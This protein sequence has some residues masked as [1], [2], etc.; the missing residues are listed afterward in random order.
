MDF[1]Q[2]IE[3]L[4][5]ALDRWNPC[6]FNRYWIYWHERKV[7]KFIS[8]NIRT[9]KGRVDWDRVISNL[10]PTLQP[11]W[12]DDRIVNL[13]PYSDPQVVERLIKKYGGRHYISFI[14]V[15]GEEE[16]NDVRNHISVTLVSLAQR[17]NVAAEE[18][19]MNFLALITGE[20]IYR[21]SRLW[22]WQQYPELL[23]EKCKYCIY[24]YRY[25]GTFI[26][27]LYT[28]LKYSALYFPK[29]QCLGEGKFGRV[30]QRNR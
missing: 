17:G 30:G 16:D 12:H 11:R 21:D 26:G 5:R 10:D 23:S 1:D 13:L 22:Q 6:R 24:H 25:T 2:A 14:Y 29:P 7:Y 20:W 15:N 18:E 28:K 27:Y 19:L 9:E 8:K 3:R 4:T